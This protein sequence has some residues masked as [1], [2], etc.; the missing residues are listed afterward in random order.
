LPIHSIQSR[1]V[2]TFRASPAI[3]LAPDGYPLP[4][5]DD[6]GLCGLWRTT[7]ALHV[8][9]KIAMAIEASLAARENCFRISTGG[10]APKHTTGEAR[11]ELLNPVSLP[12]FAALELAR[13]T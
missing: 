1:T 4:Q 3:I 5:Y 11:P 6:Y 12:T 7:P 9:V 10:C 2:E 8:L 13:M